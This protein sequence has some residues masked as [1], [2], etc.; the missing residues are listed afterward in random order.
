MLDALGLSRFSADKLKPHLKMAVHRFGILNNKK[1][2]LIK[3]D[4]REI[5]E[6]LRIGK[7]EKA[8]IKVEHIIRQDFT[9]EAYEILE[10]LCELIHER[11]RLVVAE[12]ECP[13]DMQEAVCTLIWASTR[14]ECP[15]LEEVSRQFRL[16]Y[17]KEFHQR[18]AENAGCCVND[19]VA[20]KL[21]IQPPT[22]YL[23]QQYLTNIS[24][25]YSIDWTPTDIGL[26][27]AELSVHA[28]PVPTGAS[29]PQGQGLG[30]G[31][32]YQSYGGGDPRGGGGAG[33]GLPGAGGSG[34]GAGGGGGGIPTLDAVPVTRPPPA[35]SPPGA[36]SSNQVQEATVIGIHHSQ[37]P[38][39]PRGPAQP[40]RDT[41]AGAAAAAAAAA[42]PVGVAPM[43]TDEQAKANAA[44]PPEAG[45]PT[46]IPPA[47]PIIP[48]APT[49]APSPAA[50]SAPSAPSTDA[51]SAGA[52]AG[53]EASVAFPTVPGMPTAP[54]PVTGGEGHDGSSGTDDLSIEAMNARLRMLDGTAGSPTAAP[55]GEQPSAG[56]QP[57]VGSL[58]AAPGAPAPSG[59]VEYQDLMARFNQLRS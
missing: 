10:L 9:I 16:K 28:M 48:R 42:S 59:S 21:S 32:S 29:I 50:P 2:N 33:G 23:I 20:H 6:L 12:K 47:V 52:G 4:K 39:A 54:A 7:E 11:M 19:R 22:A 18:A 17:G 55:G 27:E 8:R 56:G 44:K 31:I 57:D 34:G 15:E 3:Q 43:T 25:E 46:F 38:T 36:N 1:T 30:S 45:E 35:Y 51:A 41:P 26:T 58:P 13:V 53:A 49:S 24:K 40:T 14:T 37:P 5:A